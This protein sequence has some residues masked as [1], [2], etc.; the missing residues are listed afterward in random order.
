MPEESKEDLPE[1]FPYL[2]FENGVHLLGFVVTKEGQTLLKQMQATAPYIVSL[3]AK[4][5]LEYYDKLACMDSRVYFA[6]HPERYSDV[7][8]NAN[9]NSWL[10][11]YKFI[12]ANGNESEIT[13]STTTNP[14]QDAVGIRT[15]LQRPDECYCV[16]CV[17]CV[18]CSKCR[19]KCKCGECIC[20]KEE[21]SNCKCDLNLEFVLPAMP[22]KILC[23]N[24]QIVHEELISSM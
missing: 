24:L 15:Y 2:V 9:I 5:C 23:S 1:G 12:S 4:M 16:E 13:Y 14:P 8:F 3:A 19:P 18:N 21:K 6:A 20:K 11:S 7:Y 22:S 10:I 17:L